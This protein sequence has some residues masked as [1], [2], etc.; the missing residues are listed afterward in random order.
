MEDN[1]DF[2][3]LKT[4]GIK[5]NYLYICERKL[6]LFDRGIQ[7]ESTSDRVLQGKV[8]EQSSYPSEERK[9]IMID[10]LINIDIVNEN[11][12]RE[13]KLSN[14]ISSAD[15]IQLLYYLYFLKRVG[16]EK[17][18]VLNYPKL[19]RKEEVI[20]T[21]DAEREVTQ[22]L[23][24]VQEVLSLKNPPKVERKPYCSKCSYY[25]FCYC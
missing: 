11:E 21:E 6:W 19:R 22:S 24:R 25:E 20:L 23:K 17:K 7:M 12:I 3:S 9:K 1:L 4:N 18:G 8:L 5:V 14:K 2:D 16:V 10:N 15:R 13:V